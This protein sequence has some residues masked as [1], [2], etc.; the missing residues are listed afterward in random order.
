MSVTFRSYGDSGGAVST[1][2]VITKPAGLAIG[3]LMIAQEVLSSSGSATITPP[4]NWASIRVDGYSNLESA[5]FWKIADAADVAASNFTFTTVDTQV[6]RGTI[7]AWYGHDS[8]TPINASEGQGNA[9]STTITSDGLTPGVAS[10]VICLF[11]SVRDKN[12]QNN[13]AIATNNPASWAEAYDLPYDNAYADLGLSLGYA[14]R[15]ETSATGNGTATTSGS[16]YNIGQL[17][18]IA[19]SAAITDKSSSD[20]GSGVDTLFAKGLLMSDLGSGVEHY[21]RLIEGDTSELLAFLTKTEEGTGA[22]TLNRELETFQLGEGIET[23]IS[24]DLETLETGAGLDASVWLIFVKVSSDAGTGTEALG[25]RSL[26]IR[27]YGTGLETVQDR[28]I[29]I[30]TETGLGVDISITFTP[31]K[32]S[33]DGGV[34][35]ENVLDRD[36]FLV[37]ETGAGLDEL[38]DLLAEFLKTDTGT[39]AESVPSFER[40]LVDSGIG[41]DTMLTLLAVLNRPETGTGAERVLSRSLVLTEVGTGI[42]AVVRALIARFFIQTMRQTQITIQTLQRAKMTIQTQRQT[43]MPIETKG[44][45]SG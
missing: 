44:G 29:V 38:V 16:D 7:T 37:S 31:I 40:A 23:L 35:T 20:A 10:C 43:R 39:G 32:I 19:P 17:V 11:C 30:I 22:E 21:R 9:A 4:A 2:C 15:P 18:A 42:D 3:D 28:D 26:K 34:G 25:S 27:E 6:N 12:T 14:T 45:G 1:S 33:S 5:L 13:Y 41:T 8:T 24:R 36:I